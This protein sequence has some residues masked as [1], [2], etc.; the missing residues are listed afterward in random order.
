MKLKNLILPAFL[1]F[2]G[3]SMNDI[4]L[5]KKSSDNGICMTEP[6]WVAQPPVKEG[7][8]YGVGVAPMNF[9][10]E[11]AQR[12]SAIAKAIDEIAAQ[13]QTTVNSQTV[14]QATVYNKHASTSM[15]NV[16]F[17]TIN[18]QKVSATIIKSCK[19]PETGYLYIL[20]KANK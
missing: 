6:K 14:T 11:Q 3:C 10:G 17:Q 9:H 5:G 16:S 2:A 18:G 19:N 4:G 12:K 13:M 7:E 1:L 20:M 8:I 15:S